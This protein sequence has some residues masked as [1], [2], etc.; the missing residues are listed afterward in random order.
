M[1]RMDIFYHAMNYTSKGTVDAASRGTFRRKNAEEA[2]QLIEELVKRN[3]RASGSS[4]RLRG[5]VIEL[6]KMSEIEAK[7]DTIKNRMNNQEIIG[8]SCNEVGVV[9]GAEQKC[10]T[11][12]GLAHERPYQVEEA[13]FVNGNRS[14]NFNPNNN[15][16]THYTLALRNHDNFSFGGGMQQGPRPVQ[17]FQQIYAPPG[18]QG[19]QKFS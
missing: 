11:D 6:N 10:A 9:D 14:Y 5:R 1:T 16:P 7:L 15:L 18:F 3:Y 17:N 4:S 8:N 2:T 19:Q 12:E 13:Q